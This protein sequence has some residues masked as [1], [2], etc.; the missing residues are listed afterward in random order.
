MQATTG[1]KPKRIT[2]RYR[3]SEVVPYINWIY[4]FHAWGMEPRF[5][6]IAEVHQCPA[7]RAGWV[8]SFAPEE[9]AKAREATTLYADA[10]ALLRQWADAPLCEAL[11]MIAD[12]NSAGDDIVIDTHT[13]LP[14]LRQQH[15]GAKGYTLCLSDF[16]RPASSGTPDTIGVFATTAHIPASERTLLASTLADRL[17][18]ATAERLHEE[19]R[20]Q[21]WGY[22]KEEQ[23]TM[24]E[25]H[26]EA[27]QGIR[28]AVGYPSLPDQS[29]NFII[30]KLLDLSQIGI[31]LS[32]NGAMQPASSVSG[33]MIAH[34]QAI[35]FA[36]GEIGADQ[37][38]DYAERRGLKME[39]LQSF[40]ASN[41]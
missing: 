33:L 34:P 23:L 36:V 4:F 25:L 29:V 2:Q 9:Q 22:A 39:K 32:D 7:C 21:H 31:T 6:A 27:F 12:A 40:L 14:L 38:R 8:A 28:P 5:A 18:E 20:K 10:M 30:D 13:R 35:Y 3:V 11:C 15:A 37:L 19:V 1:Q 24:R 26:A 16:V 41:L 17:A